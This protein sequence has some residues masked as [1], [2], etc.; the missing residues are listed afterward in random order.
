MSS[1]ALTGAGAPMGTVAYMAPEQI[2][3]RDLDG[4]ADQYALACAAYELL[5]GVVPF[6]RDQEMAVI[7]AQLSAPPPALS[8]QRP[9][10]PDAAD[11]VLARALAKAPTDRYASCREFAEAVRQ[12]LGL[13]PYD[14]AP[15]SA[16]AGAAAA[17]VAPGAATVIRPAP[18]GDRRGGRELPTGD[19]TMLF[20]DIEGSTALLTPSG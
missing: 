7:Y 14:H 2:E 11:K 5:A 17:P 6:D 13:D 15:G 3:G 4:R 19:V 20:S 10:L 18:A 16:P 12:A 8:S 9:G 1:W